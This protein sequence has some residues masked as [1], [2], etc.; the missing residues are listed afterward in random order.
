MMLS[1]KVTSLTGLL[2]V[3]V[4]LCVSCLSEA[5]RKD[6]AAQG[7][8]YTGQQAEIVD[9]LR[10][11]RQEMLSNNIDR[12]LALANEAMEK[13][14]AIKDDVMRLS[15]GFWVMMVLSNA[16]EP[17]S[18]VDSIPKELLI[19]DRFETLFYGY[20]LVMYDANAFDLRGKDLLDMFFASRESARNQFEFGALFTEELQKSG[21]AKLANM[22]D[23][24]FKSYI[25][26]IKAFKDKDPDKLNE[27]KRKVVDSCDNV[28]SL[29][30][31]SKVYEDKKEELLIHRI[32]AL[33][34]KL[35][36]VGFDR[37]MSAYEKVARKH[38]EAFAMFI[39]R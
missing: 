23:T 30:N 6:G 12:A 29:M 2:T 20:L 8:F 19:S 33:H 10:Q 36:V 9:I 14:E 28:V 16:N 18:L 31:D 4:F 11:S 24:M 22:V 25:G 1:K 38:A 37:D 26:L 39:P 27:Y 5:V 17:G 13:S 3:V 34:I 7:R 21:E 32:L 15:C 35:I